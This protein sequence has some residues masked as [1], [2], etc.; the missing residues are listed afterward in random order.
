MFT[1]R[2]EDFICDNCGVA[3][4]GNGFTNHCPVC[5]WSKHV[6]VDPGD[7]K[8]SCQGMKE[9]VGVESSRVGE[10]IVY[11]CITCKTIRRNKVSK[12]DNFDAILALSRKVADTFS[13]S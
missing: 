4:K 9:P 1:K 6:D 7:R 5:L 3:V 11:R 2:I 10:S 13:N 12:D 8:E